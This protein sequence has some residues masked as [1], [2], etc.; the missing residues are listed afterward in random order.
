[1]VTAPIRPASRRLTGSQ[2]DAVTPTMTR[3]SE[4]E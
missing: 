4:E 2:A 1:M 3:S